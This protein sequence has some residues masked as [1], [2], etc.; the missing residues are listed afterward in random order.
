MKKG[1]KRM[2]E[3]P[4]LPLIEERAR[5]CILEEGRFPSCVDPRKFRFDA[6]VFSQR[7]PNTAG[8]F[9]E[10]GCLSGQAF[11]KYYITIMYEAVTESYVVFQ[12]NEPVYIV[13]NANDDFYDDV[14]SQEM[15][16][17][18]IARERY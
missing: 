17:I 16:T 15:A 5:A 13:N 6:Q 8:L 14:Y 3:Y 12:T 2:S 7:F 1:E 9:A 18:D 10:S 4:N 11:T